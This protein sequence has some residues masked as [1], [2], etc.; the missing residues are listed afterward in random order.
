LRT[1]GLPE[2]EV[3]DR[4]IG[5]EARHDVEIGYRASNSEIE[6]KILASARPGESD[7]ALRAR[8]ALAL[9]EVKAHLGDS[10]YAEGTTRLP[11]AL[12][13]LLLERNTT[14]GVA[15]SCTGGLVSQMMTSVPGASRYF[16]GGVTSYDNRV[17]E[18]VLGVNA[19]TLRT[20]GAVSEDVA[21]Q[22]AEG[23]RRVLGVECALSLTGIAGPSGGSEDKPVG[24]V[25]F[26]VATP[27][28]TTCDKRIFT[29]DRPRIQMR[30]ALTG[31]WAVR[32]HL[33]ARNR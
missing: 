25:Y 2:S 4:L 24:L 27:H 19:D 20:L 6:V 18:R 14:L 16:Y 33:L 22:M 7:E 9:G 26:A 10:V 30:A 13:Q 12:G 21:R 31:L 5:L 32:A 8:A 17:K 29:G 11:E 28:G 3:N 15:E 1:F 23:A